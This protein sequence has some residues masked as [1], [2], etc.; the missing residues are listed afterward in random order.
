MDC[1]AGSGGGATL[2]NTELDIDSPAGESTTAGAA[3]QAIAIAIA[4]N[5]GVTISDG[6]TTRG[7]NIREINFGA[8]LDVLVSS[9]VATITGQSG[10]G[11]GTGDI[12]G[13]VTA[14]NSGL[15][16]GVTTGTATL[17]L[18][19]EQPHRPSRNRGRR[20]S[21][22]RRC[23][24]VR[25]QADHGSELLAAHLAPT[26]G[27]LAP[28]TAGQL[29]IRIHG[30]TSFAALEGTDELVMTDDS[31]SANISKKITLTNFVAQIAGANLT[32]TNGVLSAAAG[33]G[34]GTDTNDYVDALNT[35]VLGQDV[36]VTLSAG[37]VR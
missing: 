18:V 23:E 26:G 29:G 1:P 10:G 28:T 11:G 3:R 30:M 24:R 6:G 27:G 22:L 35:A 5:R 37:R 7:T 12:T 4:G 20:P 32:A 17:T 19:P 31:T 36:T 13:V 16:G 21:P 8:N 14:A 33:G 34:G 25:Q 9:G 15:A 2:T